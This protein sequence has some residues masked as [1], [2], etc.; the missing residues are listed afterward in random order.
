M[1][2]AGRPYKKYRLIVEIFV[3]SLNA[4][5]DHRDGLI[6]LLGSGV[7]QFLQTLTP[8]LLGIFHHK[9]DE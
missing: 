6:T 4:I 7:L 9:A 1:N 8:L 3:S 2:L 5:R